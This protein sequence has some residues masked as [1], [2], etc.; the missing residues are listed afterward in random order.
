MSRKL[1]NEELDRKNLDQYR[2]AN[3]LPI[4]IILDNIRSLHNVGSV[5]RTSDSF[6]I[7]KLILCGITGTP[8]HREIEKSALG[9]TES[10]EWSYEESTIDAVRRYKHS[11]YTAIAVEQTE[12]STMLRELA[13]NKDERLALI[14]GQEINGVSQEVVD[15]CD[16]CVEI[17]QYGT[18]HSF[19]IAVTTG[20]VLW[21]I[22]NKLGGK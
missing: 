19:N 16:K 4:V 22:S 21:E 6:L 3:K 8:P 14:F 13:V 11:G 2:K 18:K 9:A 12:G 1:L 20:I 15:M 17:P 10:V 7:E 5:F